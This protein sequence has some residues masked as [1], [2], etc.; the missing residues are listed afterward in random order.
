M[1]SIINQ[2]LDKINVYVKY[3][4]ITNHLGKVITIDNEYKYFSI[5]E[6]ITFLNMIEIYILNQ[7]RIKTTFIFHNV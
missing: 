5:D 3:N 2:C 7:P 6:I 1:K 4:N